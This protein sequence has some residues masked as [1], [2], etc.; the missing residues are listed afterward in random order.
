MARPSFSEIKQVTETSELGQEA[1]K[2]RPSFQQVK[3]QLQGIP[4]GEF[5][6]ELPTELYGPPEPTPFEESEIAI[7][8][9]RQVA[10]GAS[11]GF[12]EPYFGWSVALQQTISD[13]V[14]ENKYDEAKSLIEKAKDYY[15]TEQKR[16]EEFAI[17]YPSLAFGAETLG[18]IIPGSAAAKLAVQSPSMIKSILGTGAAA[19]TA[20]EASKQLTE[21]P[22]TEKTVAERTGEAALAPVIGAGMAAV[23][24]PVMMGG[25]L[26]IE[27]AEQ[28]AKAGVAGYKKGGI[29]KGAEATLKEI[30]DI[31]KGVGKEVGKFLSKPSSMKVAAKIFS[32]DP[33]SLQDYLEFQKEIEKLDSREQVEQFFGQLQN[34]IQ[35]LVD[36]NKLELELAQ[37]AVK[38]AEDSL[39]RLSGRA[40]QDQKLKLDQAQYE[41]NNINNNLERKR[42]NLEESALAQKE[43]YKFGIEA[44]KTDVSTEYLPVVDAIDDLLT[45]MKEGSEKAYATLDDNETIPRA[46]IEK[47]IRTIQKGKALEAAKGT[48]VGKTARA[49]VRDLEKYIEALYP[50]PPEGLDPAGL[51]FWQ[52]NIK[53]QEVFTMKELKNVLRQIDDD[54]TAKEFAMG[55]DLYRSSLMQVRRGID[56][57]LKTN[58][59]YEQAMMPVS[60]LTKFYNEQIVPM[61]GSKDAP[62]QIAARMKSAATRERDYNTFKTLESLTGVKVTEPIDRLKLLAEKRAG[63]A[64][65]EKELPEVK[66]LD[67]LKALVSLNEDKKVDIEILQSLPP[68]MQ[69]VGREIIKLRNKINDLT[70]PEKKDMEFSFATRSGEATLEMANENVKRL[71]QREEALDSIAKNLNFA[72]AGHMVDEF[73]R[74]PKGR[75]TQATAIA[76]KALEQMPEAAVANIL[77]T[78]LLDN[79]GDLP[80]FVKMLR[81]RQAVAGEEKISANSDLKPYLIPALIGAAG[82]AYA[83]SSRVWSFAGAIGGTLLKAYNPKITV[84]Y[85]SNV[86]ALRGL[87]TYNK[88]INAS[89]VVLP[90]EVRTS[91]SNLILNMINTNK[92]KQSELV[93]VSD[94]LI[95]DTIYDIKTS[96][97][98]NI[99]KAKAIQNL[100]K[101]KLIER[102]TINSLMMEGM[103]VSTPKYNLGARLAEPKTPKVFKE[104]RPDVLKAL[105]KPKIKG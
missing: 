28:A 43:E 45:K 36:D 98:N 102:K 96:S 5:I 56:N 60:D 13:L 44:L 46:E 81:A 57:I 11:L 99:E 8:A 53:S 1:T 85:L 4:S 30:K 2:T 33:K 31:A 50:A 24:T 14:S 62:R 105:T 87:P 55:T 88:L 68:E 20:M 29:A 71:K 80:K 23:T 74:N 12:T 100:S 58:K 19:F 42:L 93:P 97:M 78:M 3:A 94:D 59:D 27:A 70:M 10:K 41:L 67:Q 75:E 76:L 69:A 7:R 103:A 73:L 38:E 66:Q 21:L 51:S 104:D 79:P 18:G 84:K 39:G 52:E 61:L 95:I 37:K 92:E 16:Q 83:T 65:F 26:G 86:N 34:T 17:K 48:V 25:M 40:T 82:G 77:K 64:R 89:P 9:S 47:I 54:I 49:V 35:K 6:S 63:R 91:V 32:K 15:K 90:P 22:Y 72:T 101:F